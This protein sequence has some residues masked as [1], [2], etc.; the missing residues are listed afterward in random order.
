[1]ILISKDGEQ[2]FELDDEI[3]IA[4]S[5][6]LR[7]HLEQYQK[8]DDEEESMSNEDDTVEYQTQIKFPVLMKLL[9]LIQQPKIEIPKPIP[10]DFTLDSPLMDDSYSE[11]MELY[12]AA[13]ML[14]VSE[15]IDLIAG[16]IG[17]YLRTK[18]TSE[19]QSYFGVEGK[20]L[21]PQADQVLTQAYPWISNSETKPGTRKRTAPPHYTIDLSDSD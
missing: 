10:S 3:A 21:S 17:I 19:I 13:S 5:E 20:S 8:E 16:I 1:M 9:I 12:Q 2:K 4:N 7:K 18:T 11:L 6:V 14:Q 15:I